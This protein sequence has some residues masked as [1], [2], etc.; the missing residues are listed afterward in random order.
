VGALLANWRPRH[1]VG[2]LLLVFGL[3]SAVNGVAAGYAY[4]LSA[5]RPQEL[6]AAGAAALFAL[7]SF[8]LIPVAMNFVMLLTPA[9]RCPRRA[10]GPLPP[11][12]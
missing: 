9:G 2:W 4:Y 11:S 3:A 1:P 12:S 8:Y 7:L 5:T 6:R 10:G